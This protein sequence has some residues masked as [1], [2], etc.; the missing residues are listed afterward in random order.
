MTSATGVHVIFTAGRPFS[1][2]QAAK[3]ASRKLTRTNML[4]VAH[5]RRV[6]HIVVEQWNTNETV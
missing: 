3:R 1:I 4:F 2:H 6:I 5:P